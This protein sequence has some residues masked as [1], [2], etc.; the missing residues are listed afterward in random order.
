M[1]KLKGTKQGTKIEFCSFLGACPSKS[2][3]FEMR[4]AGNSEVCGNWCEVW[5]TEIDRKDSIFPM[6]ASITAYSEGSTGSDMFKVQHGSAS[7]S[8]IC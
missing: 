5:G 6:P 2:R 4:F 3:G 1:Y 8:S 7:I